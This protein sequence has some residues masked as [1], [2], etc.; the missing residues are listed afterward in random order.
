MK[1]LINIFFR[2][3]GL[4]YYEN[5]SDDNNNDCL[6]TKFYNEPWVKSCAPSN[7][8]FQVDRILKIKNSDRHIIKGFW[9]IVSKMCFPRHEYGIK[10]FRK[11]TSNYHTQIFSKELKMAYFRMTSNKKTKQVIKPD[12]P[13]ETSSFSGWEKKTKKRSK[14]FTDT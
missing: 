2:C 7:V 8:F 14:T 11:C 5:C 4:S 12:A 1:I 6:V 10:Q 3:V 9:N 13:E